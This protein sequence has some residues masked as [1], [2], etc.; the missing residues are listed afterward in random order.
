MTAF[1]LV[2]PHQ[3]AGDQPKA[4]E[5]LSAVLS[6]RPD[7]IV[8]ITGDHGTG[9][10]RLESEAVYD[11]TTDSIGERMSV[12]SAYRLGACSERIYPSMTPVNGARTITSCALGTELDLV[13][14]LSLWA[15]HDGNGVV[16]DAAKR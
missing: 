8:M 16:I 1:Q 2:S 11:W 13:P 5:A 7:T 3:P 6:A 15:P 4:I 14:D 12:F 9:S 10:T